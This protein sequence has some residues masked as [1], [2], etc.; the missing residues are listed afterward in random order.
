MALVTYILLAALQSGLQ[1]R[2]HPEILGYS[3]SK[4][5]LVV[6]CDYLFV[7]LGC[8]FLNIQ[9]TAQSF[10]IVSY[11]GYKFVGYVILYL[12]LRGNRLMKR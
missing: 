9:G 11:G 2:F 8:Y 10:D 5:L 12:E 4:A 6:L 1:A 7:K 3:A